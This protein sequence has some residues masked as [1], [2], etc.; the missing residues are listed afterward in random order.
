MGNAAIACSSEH[1]RVV[2]ERDGLCEE[3]DTLSSRLQAVEGE[4]GALESEKVER[5][6]K[7]AEATKELARLEHEWQAMKQHAE[8]QKGELREE[9]IEDIVE[10]KRLLVDLYKLQDGFAKT[11]ANVTTIISAQI[12]REIAGTLLCC[13]P[14]CCPMLH[15]SFST[16]PPRLFRTCCVATLRR[17]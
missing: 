5:D 2:E 6:A 7:L 17:V 12:Q 11:L 8:A 1:K 9:R 16:T 10:R 14:W 13:F 15:L 3:R 4:K